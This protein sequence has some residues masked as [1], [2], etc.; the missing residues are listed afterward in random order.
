MILNSRLNAFS[1]QI[2]INLF[3]ILF[4]QVFGC[5]FMGVFSLRNISDLFFPIKTNKSVECINFSLKRCISTKILV[6][7]CSKYQGN[8]MMIR[9]LKFFQPWKKFHFFFYLWPCVVCWLI[10]MNTALCCI[11]CNHYMKKSSIT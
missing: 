11:F 10:N 7:L 2:T 1:M 4:Y 6:F 9:N 8:E 5:K 3:K